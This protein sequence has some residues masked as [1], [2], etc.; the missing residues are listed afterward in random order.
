MSRE[1]LE[2]S[3]FLWTRALSSRSRIWN[4]AVVA[5]AAMVL[6]VFAGRGEARADGPWTE[7]RLSLKVGGFWPSVDTQVRLDATSQTPGTSIDFENLLGLDDRK[8]LLDIEATFRLGR[9]N[10]FE[11]EYFA[12]DRSATANLSATIDFG[13]Q[14][15]TFGTN[16]VSSFNFDLYRAGYGFSFINNGRAELGVSVGLHVLRMDVSISDVGG[17]LSERGDA[18][19]PLPNLGVYGSIE[20]AE[21]VALVGRAQVFYLKAGD[22]EGRLLNF[23]GAVEYYP[24]KHLGLG[25][26]YAYF[27]LDIEADASDF[28]G[29]FQFQ[30]HGPVAYIKLWF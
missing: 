6:S 21:N 18:A 30:Q 14:T 17:M 7:E 27:D 28:S 3:A 4:L 20:V 22:F 25:L 26:G 1:T 8:L 19:L 11:F 2:C 5:L 13:D 10:R 24:I 23:S 16:V 29:E 9:R 12:L 15:F